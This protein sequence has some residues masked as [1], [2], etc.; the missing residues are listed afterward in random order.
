MFGMP[1]SMRK[2]GANNDNG[3]K[4]EFE[5]VYK[6][7][8]ENLLCSIPDRSYDVGTNKEK[9]SLWKSMSNRNENKN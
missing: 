1:E 9:Y 5:E 3:V 2:E 6:K 7:S 8:T 4:N